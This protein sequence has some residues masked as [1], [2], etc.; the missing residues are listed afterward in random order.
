MD[1]TLNIA[2]KEYF[3]HKKNERENYGQCYVAFGEYCKSI[4]YSGLKDLFNNKITEY[5]LVHSCM[6]YFQNSKKAKGIEAINRYLSAIDSFYSE[7]ISKLGGITCPALEHGCRNKELIANICRNLQQDL[8]REI[9]VPISNNELNNLYTVLNQLKV[10]NYFQYGQKVICELLLHY[11]F[12]LN[13]IIS[14]SMAD[15]DL[16]K[17]YIRVNN[18]RGIYSIKIHKNILSHMNCYNQIHPYPDRTYFFTNTKGQRLNSNSILP[19]V[20]AKLST[21]QNNI[22]ATTIALNGIA[23]LI[24]KGLTIS[25]IMRITGFE[26]QKIVDVS[27]YLIGTNDI[28]KILNEKL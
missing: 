17:G 10:N 16:K 20:K 28:D 15:V 14:L 25:E 18:R 24:E 19:T 1:N 22:T 11:G 6:L 3:A 23:L 4:Q 27:E 8:K 5:E 9:Y 12:K 7:Y 13:I 2:V 26:I 21:T